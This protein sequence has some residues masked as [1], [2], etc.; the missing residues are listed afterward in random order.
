MERLDEIYQFNLSLFQRNNIAYKEWQHEPIR[1]FATDERVSKELGMTGTMSKSLF[2]KIKGGGFAL[3]LTE[4]DKRLDKKAVKDALGKR[5]SICTPEEMTAE[6]GCLSG[7]VCPFGL[8]EEIP[9]IIDQEMIEKDEILYTPAYPEKTFSFAGSDLPA[10]L[11]QLPNT[12][13]M[14]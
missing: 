11:S 5:V 2:L 9:M 14:I 6:I 8:P 12:I 7:A 13:H 4:K 10:L 3:L 1:D